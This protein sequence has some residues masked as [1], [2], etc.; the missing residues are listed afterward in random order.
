[1]RA[2]GKSGF[3]LA[4][5]AL[6]Y[7]LPALAESERI[8]LVLG[9][10]G[11]RGAAHVGVLKVLE[12]QQIAVD[13]IVGT[14]MGAIVG[15]LYAS[16][17]RPDEIEAI[18]H[19]IDWSDTLRDQSQRA[20][21]SPQRKADAALIP[22]TLEIGIGPEGLRVPQG[23]LQGQ[24][25]GLLLRELLVGTRRVDHFDQLP[26]PFRAVA[27]DLVT[28]E[29]VVLESG[30]LVDAVRASMSVPGAFQ[31]IRIDDRL[32]V[33]GGIVD[34]VP[35]D[36]ARSMGATRLIVV[37]VG[38]GLM[39]EDDL[40]SPASV[41]MQVISILMERQTR[42]TLALA[43][44]SDVVIRP[45]LG[46]IGSAD[47]DRAVEAVPLGE[48][49]ALSQLDQLVSLRADAQRWSGFVD[50]DGP[51]QSVRRISAI[52]VDERFS[53]T[54]F[55]LRHRLQDLIG[56]PA[57]PDLLRSRIAEL[58]GDGYYERISYD[59]SDDGPGDVVLELTPVDKHWGPNFLRLGLRLSDDFD[60]GSAYQ[61]D[62]LARLASEV[63]PGSEWRLRLG[64]GEVNELAVGWR[65]PFGERG[66]AYWL[67]QASLRAVDQPLFLDDEDTEFARL[68]WTRGRVAGDLGIDWNPRLRTLIRLERGQDRLKRQIG[69][70]LLAER[71]RQNYGFIALGVNYDSLDDAAFPTRGTLFDARVERHASW[72]GSDNASTITR[73]DWTRAAS[74]GRY[75]GM[76]GLRAVSAR[77]DDVSLQA[78]DFLGGLG[79]LSGYAERSLAGPQLFLGRVLLMRRLGATESLMSLPAYLGIS[80]EAGNVW[81]ARED[82][83]LDDLVYSGSLYLGVSTPLGPIF[84]GYGRSSTERQAIYLNFGSLVRSRSNL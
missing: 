4:V 20:L 46:D 76:A 54:A 28:G 51:D 63:R 81:D 44:P 82:F 79:N 3:F 2:R 41:T 73:I 60:G 45:D 12:E 10:G 80:A 14:S 34:N 78:L 35:V 48:V 62:A 8:G 83:D 18:L 52:T 21:Q 74:A 55:L 77:D 65:L 53:R 9:G 16:G 15:S 58:Y 33:D 59:L 57:E 19:R 30:D 25:L 70:G 1:M 72:L 17:Y 64:L 71:I 26:I 40:G 56:Q 69:S 13:L 67:P 24:K 47:F 27:A 6:L 39:N 23:L 38:A 37:D 68:R 31:P 42:N 84:L 66:R 32:L 22:S 11:A 61:I 75:L 49:A 43:D 7:S 36:V 5:A 50:R 29:M